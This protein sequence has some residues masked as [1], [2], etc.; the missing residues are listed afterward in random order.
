L[1][2]KTTDRGKKTEGGVPVCP[3]R[4]PASFGSRKGGGK[5]GRP[6]VSGN[7]KSL[8]VAATAYADFLRNT[9]VNSLG[10]EGRAACS[11]VQKPAPQTK[12][13]TGA[14]KKACVLGR[15]KNSVIGNR[16]RGNQGRAD[17]KYGSGDQKL[18]PTNGIRT[19][20]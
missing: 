12:E 4:R 9:R 14:V 1:T 17:G 18:S 11:V 7:C 6:F 2:E 10:K 3:A 16:A 13:R 15:S 19:T 8:K 5:T 20:R